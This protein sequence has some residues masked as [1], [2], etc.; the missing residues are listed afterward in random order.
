MTFLRTARGIE[1]L[2][3]HRGLVAR[4]LRVQQGEWTDVMEAFHARTVGSATVTERLHLLADI[5]A[6][7][8]PD[9]QPL[10][11]AGGGEQ[12]PACGHNTVRARYR[13]QLPGGLGAGSFIYGLCGSPLPVNERNAPSAEFCRHAVLLAGAAS[14]AVYASPS[15][16]QVRGADGAGYTAYE[17]E[18]QYR[19]AKGE[20][21]LRWA[22]MQ[23]ARSPGSL[24][25]IG[26]GFGFTRRAAEELGLTSMGVDLNP[27]AADGAQ[28]LYGLH[29]HTGTLGHALDSRS[30]SE[31]SVDMMLYDF[32]LEHVADP[33]AEL[34]LAAR[35]LVP[36]GLLVVRVPGTE[37]LELLPFGSYYRSFRTDHLHL[38]SRASLTAMLRGTGFEPVAFDTECR[39]HLLQEVLTQSELHASYAAG[40]GPD[41]AACALRRHHALSPRHSA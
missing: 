26:S 37:A 29:T 8:F 15:Y 1:A 33:I 5:F 21:L 32:V 6:A 31:E 34:K 14:S 12:C 7:R 36:G 20:R 35:V 11:A 10:D 38:F 9:A 19:E 39:A 27:A 24:L 18:R 13:R 41:I 2:D 40:L 3:E 16:Y 4:V 25:E 22:L 17:T 30:L 28:R 23:A